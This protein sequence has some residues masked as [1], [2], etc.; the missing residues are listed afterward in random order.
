MVGAIRDP[1]TREEGKT[2]DGG[3]ARKQRARLKGWPS[4]EAD[5]MRKRKTNK[6][7]WSKWYKMEGEV[8]SEKRF[9]SG[10]VIEQISLA[11]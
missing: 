3:H 6:W 5:E 10:P 7:W 8:E 2:S 1:K 4:G 11:S 9:D